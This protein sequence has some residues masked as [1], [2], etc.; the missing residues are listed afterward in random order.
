MS[1]S[2]VAKPSIFQPLLH[3][4]LKMTLPS[5]FIRPVHPKTQIAPVESAIKK[6]ID[7][8]WWGQPKI[9]GHR[10]QIHI[11]ADARPCLV[12][13]RQG[14]L[15]KEQLTVGLEAELRRLFSP[16]KDWNTIDAEWMKSDQKI[17]VFDFLKKDGVLLDQM[18]FSERY[19]LIPKLYLSPGIST[20]PV[21]KTTEKCMQFLS[22]RCAEHLE[23]LVFRAAHSRGF[24]DGSIVRCRFSI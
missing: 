6:V 14:Q 7:A 18:S 5:R 9:N 15:H 12:Y 17:F 23:G 10:A 21:L 20:L 2:E 24:S 4:R 8:G 16:T 13:N 3:R 22:T 11:P 1:L 19:D